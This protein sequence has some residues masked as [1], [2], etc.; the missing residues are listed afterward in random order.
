MPIFAVLL[1]YR[2]PTLYRKLACLG[3]EIA[4]GLAQAAMVME[5]FGMLLSMCWMG[6]EFMTLNREHPRS[7]SYAQNTPRPSDPPH[8]QQTRHK[9]QIYER[10]SP[11]HPLFYSAQVGSPAVGHDYHGIAAFSTTNGGISDETDLTHARTAPKDDETITQT[12]GIGCA[13][14]WGDFA[15]GC[16]VFSKWSLLHLLLTVAR[17]PGSYIMCL[18]R[19]FEVLDCTLVT[20]ISYSM[21]A[22]TGLPNIRPSTNLRPRQAKV[23]V[24]GTIGR[25][26]GLLLWNRPATCSFPLASGWDRVRPPPCACCLPETLCLTGNLFLV[27]EAAVARVDGAVIALALL[28]EIFTAEL[29]RHRTALF[30]GY[31]FVPIG[32]HSPRRRRSQ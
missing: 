19:D 26:G 16:L 28:N 18:S 8:S 20:L 14:C 30:P 11:P 32:R 27:K 17:E 12:L 6:A 10:A 23:Y 31:G 25:F 13:C 7:S 24:L 5:S 3:D 21:H 22:A 15:K 29:A 9:K 1:I 4:S 2:S